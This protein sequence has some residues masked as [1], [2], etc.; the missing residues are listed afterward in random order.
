MIKF[1]NVIGFINVVD[2]LIRLLIKY[3]NINWNWFIVIFK[4]CVW[5]FFKCK[6]FKW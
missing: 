1:K 4:F 3:N 6:M 5:W 2:K